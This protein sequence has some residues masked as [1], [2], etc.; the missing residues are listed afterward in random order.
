METLATTI[1]EKEIKVI[2][3]GNE[4]TKLSL[5]T[6]DMIAYGQNPI[7]IQFIYLWINFALPGVDSSIFFIFL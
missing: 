3:I 5:F 4:D 2:N 1:Q 6:A 7:E